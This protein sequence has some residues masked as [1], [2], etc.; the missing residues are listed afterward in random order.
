MPNAGEVDNTLLHAGWEQRDEGIYPDLFGSP[1]GD[2]ELLTEE[3]FKQD[4]G[5]K[6]VH[7]FWLHHGVLT[8]APTSS[9][10][11]W[12][13]ATT[14]MSTA[15]DSEVD[16]W[17]G[18]GVEFILETH[19]QSDW[20]ADKLARLMAFN[21]LI[22]IGH[23]KDLS[24]MRAGSLV[25]LDVPIDRRESELRNVVA[26]T[27][28]D[29]P[30]EF[31]LVTGKAEFLQMVAITDT[32]ADFVDAMGANKLAEKLVAMPDRFTINPTRKAIL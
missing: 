21:L 16:D 5:R 26:L 27:P 8:F 11:T 10:K 18:L 9:R 12:L 14:G 15:F 1:E 22:A 17:S 28:A 32:E 25:R 13:Y 4:F 30:S 19:E 3:I 29:H 7:P 6:D 31:H 20:A 23:Y 24:D 2:T